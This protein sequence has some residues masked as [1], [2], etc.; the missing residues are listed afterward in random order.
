[1]HVRTTASCRAVSLATVV[2]VTLLALAACGGE[3][4]ITAAEGRHYLGETF[5]ARA[6]GASLSR[7]VYRT[8]DEVLPNVAYEHDNG[9]RTSI[10]THVAVGRILDV[11][12]GKGFRI[13]GDDA[14]GG[15][16]T[17]FDDP[18]ARWWTVHVSLGVDRGIGS[19]LPPTVDFVLP[20]G[21]P[22]EFP[23]MSAGVR[24]LG[25]VV[26]F[27]R[28][29]S[30]LTAYD[31]N[32]YWAIE[33]EGILLATVGADGRLELPLMPPDRAQE[34]LRAT[35]RLGDLEAAGRAPRTIHTKAG[36]DPNE[37]ERVD[38]K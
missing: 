6:A 31:S 13:E 32:L 16:T 24:T 15:I 7:G 25:R 22:D 35:P 28:S 4:E 5:R 3:R 26:A 8:L 30:P 37:P 33:E 19:R 27:L 11:R 14:P 21:G 12:K 34:L 2:A 1:M 18:R 20:S 36:S 17:D 38:G 10:A 23:V 29:D 9:R